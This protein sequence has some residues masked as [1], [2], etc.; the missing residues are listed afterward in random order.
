MS[1]TVTLRLDEKNYELFKVYAERDHRTL[2]N[3]IETSALRFIESELYCDDVEMEEIK[4]DGELNESLKKG[5]E[6]FEA[7]RGSFVE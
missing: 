3:F 2:S 5:H 7:Q 1:R 4:N 6:D